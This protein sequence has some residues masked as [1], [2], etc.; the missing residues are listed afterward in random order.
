MGGGRYGRREVWEEGGREGGGEGGMGGGRDGGREGWG[1]GGRGG[2]GEGRRGGGEGEAER[3]RARE[4]E[5]PRRGAR[6]S[7]QRCGQKGGCNFA[8]T[9]QCPR[10][11]FDRESAGDVVL[12]QDLVLG[13]EAAHAGRCTLDSGAMY[14]PFGRFPT[15]AHWGVTIDHSKSA[16]KLLV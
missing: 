6:R 13:L 9:L 12:H 10:R 15:Q 3:E 11:F 2:G 14:A 5:R 1:E 7:R 8:T 4:R 16:K